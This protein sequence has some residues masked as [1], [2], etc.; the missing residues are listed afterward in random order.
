MKN[1]IFAS[2]GNYFILIPKNATVYHTIIITNSTQYNFFYNIQQLLHKER[3]GLQHCG[4]GEIGSKHKRGANVS[5][6]CLAVIFFACTMCGLL[7][8]RMQQAQRNHA[9]NAAYTIYQHICLYDMQQMFD[10]TQWLAA[11]CYF[12][13]FCI[14]LSCCCCCCCL[15]AAFKFNQQCMLWPCRLHPV[16]G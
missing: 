3:G 14:L 7:F 13:V 10:D 12:A 8:F 4:Q 9:A 5:T 11:Y 6:L 15:H 2:L 16:V 1:L